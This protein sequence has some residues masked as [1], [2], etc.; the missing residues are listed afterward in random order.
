MFPDCTL[1]KMVKTSNPSYLGSGDQEDQ[2]LRPVQAKS[3]EDPISTNKLAV[4]A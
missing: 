3:Y 1:K 2:G 4:V